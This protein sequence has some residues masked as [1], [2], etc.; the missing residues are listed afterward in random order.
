M[1]H[2]RISYSSFCVEIWEWNISMLLNRILIIPVVFHL[3]VY[4][5]CRSIPLHYIMA[6][7]WKWEQFVAIENKYALAL[8]SLNLAWVSKIKMW[9]RKSEWANETASQSASKSMCRDK[10]CKF[11]QWNTEYAFRISNEVQRTI[12]AYRISFWWIPNARKSMRFVIHSSSFC[13]FPRTAALAAETLTM[14]AN[15]SCWIHIF[16]RNFLQS[17][18]CT[19]TFSWNIMEMQDMK[20]QSTLFY[21]CQVCLSF[22]VCLSF[23]MEKNE[24]NFSRTNA[25]TAQ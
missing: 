18:Q 6:S 24:T 22:A 4:S 21:C 13:K 19:L 15:K 11:T 25:H 14:F 3:L 2:H 20:Q 10:K 7:A 16:H 5:R 12:N 1:I 17:V 9:E 23:L 8:P